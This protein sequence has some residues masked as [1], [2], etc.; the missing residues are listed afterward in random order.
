MSLD[1]SRE[2]QQE[3]MLI[4]LADSYKKFQDQNFDKLAEAPSI[5]KK[6][7]WLILNWRQHWKLIF[8]ACIVVLAIPAYKVINTNP[9]AILGDKTPLSSNVNN[10]YEKL[11]LKVEC[12][13]DFETYGE[14]NDYGYSTYTNYC[15]KKTLPGYWVWKNPYWYIWER[16]SGKN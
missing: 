1:S 14:F 2:L 13:E 3:E 15:G 8:L 9:V 4:Q 7:R 12:S 5:I 11:L 10:K 6:I 16:Q